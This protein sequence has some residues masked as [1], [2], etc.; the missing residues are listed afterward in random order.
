MRRD[1]LCEPGERKILGGLIIF[2][3][4]TRPAI[5]SDEASRSVVTLQHQFSTEQLISL[6]I[7]STDEF[8]KYL[9]MRFLDPYRRVRRRAI[10]EHEKNSRQVDA[11][12]H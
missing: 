8:R 4:R 6:L 3:S 9:E 12:Q 5:R 10:F 11:I 7:G 1:G 2:T